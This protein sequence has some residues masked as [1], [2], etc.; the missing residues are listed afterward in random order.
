MTSDSE[1]KYFLRDPIYHHCKLHVPFVRTIPYKTRRILYY[2]FA[3]LIGLVNMKVNLV[4][5]HTVPWR[6]EEGEWRVWRHRDKYSCWR[7]G[8][9]WVH[10]HIQH[11]RQTLHAVCSQVWRSEHTEA[12]LVQ[13]PSQPMILGLCAHPVKHKKK[14]SFRCLG[15]NCNNKMGVDWNK[16]IIIYVIYWN[17]F[18]D[19]N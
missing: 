14:L 19:L 3:K 2:I 1:C 16:F 7:G 15:F 11:A 12:R 9:T 17:G 18:S 5:C 10:P 4:A 8:H 13:S 6:C